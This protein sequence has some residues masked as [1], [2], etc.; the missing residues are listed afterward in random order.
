M[1]TAST[2]RKRITSANQRTISKVNDRLHGKGWVL[3]QESSTFADDGGYS[4]IDSDVTP[5]DRRTWTSWTI[6]GFWSSDALNS[7]GWEAP[8]SIIAA[9]LTWREAIYL[10]KSSLSR[11]HEINI[12]DGNLHVT[13]LAGSFVDTIPLVLNGI[14]GAHYHIS[15][16]VAIRS[17]FGFYFSRFAVVTRAITALFWHAIQTWTGS[18]AM[19]QIIRAIFPS[20]RNLHNAFPESAGITSAQLVA[21]F[22]FW[23]IQFPILLIPP[24]KLKWFF[25]FK[26]VLVPL[27]SV[28]VVIAM[29][30][31]AGG[32]GDIWNQ[33]YG[34]SGTTKAWVMM[35]SF[36]S[37]CGSWATMATNIP[38]FTR[39]MRDGSRK[40]VFWQALALPFISI[41]L[42][43]FGIISTSAS[44]VVYDEYIWSPIDLA[45]KWEGPLGRFGAF[46]VGV[47]WVVA[48]I[49]TNLS[50]NVVSC[51]NDLTGLFPKYINIRRGVILAT[52]T[53]GW[54]MVPWKIVHSAST[55]LTFMAGLSVFLA[56][57]AAILASDY[58]IVKSRNFDV[59][60]LYRRHARYRYNSYG[61]NWR[62]VVAFLVSVTPNV[63]GLAHAVNPSIKL[64]GGIQHI[65]DMSYL[66]GF[67]S[68]AIVYVV[69]SKVWPAKETLLD[70]PIYED[71]S[72]VDGVEFKGNG[73]HGSRVMVEDGLGQKVLSESKSD[74]V[75]EKFERVDV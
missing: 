46:S 36:S 54:I 48:Q 27:V 3:E 70:G 8:S 59:P 67:L 63:P 14:I 18:L 21:H 56:P 11:L 15:F 1:S 30:K 6:L 71:I 17:S 20:F 73:V 7:Q 41:L 58:W 12:K 22:I 60:A 32:T 10:S 25:A 4:N 38:D 39:Y 65:Y 9:G 31:M 43:M 69:L 72:V 34:V 64:S 19:Y 13:A 52:I 2:L 16:P 37:V 5:L 61:T 29:T 26:T 75:V 35:S 66:W 68:A 33:P 28:G 23:S 50:A 51:S 53:A 47:C 55:L 62:A 57:V 42:A 44:K 24:H 40:G 74:I 45:D 49:G